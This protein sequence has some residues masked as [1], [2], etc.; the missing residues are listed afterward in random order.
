MNH[1]RREMLGGLTATAAA[2]A[3]VMAG[4]SIPTPPTPTLKQRLL[5]ASA[6]MLVTT[7]TFDPNRYG[8]GA[9]LK[10]TSYLKLRWAINGLREVKVLNQWGYLTPIL[11]APDY[12]MPRKPDGSLYFRQ[13]CGIR[14]IGSDPVAE[15]G[16]REDE[17]ADNLE[18]VVEYSFSVCAPE[19]KMI[20]ARMIREPHA[21][22]TAQEKTKTYRQE[23]RAVSDGSAVPDISAVDKKG[24]ITCKYKFIDGTW[25]PQPLA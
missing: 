5:P 8:S 18:E 15:L 10:P 1:T 20:L 4:A 24:R 13:I 12:A 16:Y 17:F 23:Y 19:S 11:L 22:L 25:K 14:L 2:I 21:N 7:T 6:E 9:E 3:S